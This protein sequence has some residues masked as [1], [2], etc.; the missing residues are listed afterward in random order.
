M[1]ALKKV[2]KV[3]ASLPKKPEAI[4]GHAK[5]EETRYIIQNGRGK[6]GAV[7]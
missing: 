3:V 7:P 4:A 2:V 6:C 5:K 1:Y